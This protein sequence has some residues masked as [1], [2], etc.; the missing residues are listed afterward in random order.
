MT[1]DDLRA[2]LAYEVDVVDAARMQAAGD[3]VIVDTR[4]T[5]SWDHGHARGALHLPAS[6]LEQADGVRSALADVGPGTPLILYG[7]GPGCNGA[8]RTAVPLLEAGFDVREM[9]GGFEYWARNGLPLDSAAG[10]VTQPP[11][12]LVTADAPLR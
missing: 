4:R 11:D 9:I 8:T 5:E 10:D 3:A 1:P 6:V 2:R 7:W 12:P